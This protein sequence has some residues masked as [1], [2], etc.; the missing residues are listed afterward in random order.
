NLYGWLQ[1]GPWGGAF[2][3]FAMG[4]MVLLVPATLIGGTMPVMGRL[5]G[6]RGER[7]ASS[8]SLLYG[9]DTLG[10]VLGAS[11]TGFIFLRYLGMAETLLI[12]VG[13]NALVALAAGLASFK[14]CESSNL[15]AIP[16]DATSSSDP[17]DDSPRAGRAEY[18][19]LGCAALT[20]AAALG[21]EV[22]WT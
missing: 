18:A 11:L 6:R 8:F 19:A 12:A 17:G 16:V 20:G 22:A 5:I 14:L 7:S 10:A 13:L 2:L 15:H 21:L 3:R 4:L 9:I 1:P